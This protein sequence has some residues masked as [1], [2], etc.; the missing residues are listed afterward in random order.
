MGIVRI[1]TSPA[2][3][4]DDEGA[5][6]GEGRTGMSRFQTVAKNEAK[7]AKLEA[8]MQDLMWK[9]NLIIFV[10]ALLVGAVLMYVAVK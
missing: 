10:F 3:E 2:L 4:I 5:A 7:E 9:F 1:C 6:E 8:M